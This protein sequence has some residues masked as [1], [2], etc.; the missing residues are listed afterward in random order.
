MLKIE[1]KADLRLAGMAP[2]LLRACKAL[3]V[4]I[5]KQQQ[6]HYRGAYDDG[7]WDTSTQEAVRVA[8]EAIAKAE[9]ANAQD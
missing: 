6:N 4:D 5:D 3:L 8:R 7:T 1:S 2:E 9:G